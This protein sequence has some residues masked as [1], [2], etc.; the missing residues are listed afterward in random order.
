IEILSAENGKVVSKFVVE[1][2]HLNINK[3]LFGGYLACLVDIGGSF[4]IG[5]QSEKLG[6]ST[7][8]QLSFLRSAKEGDVVI[9]ESQLEKMGRNVA[10]TTVRLSVNGKPIAHG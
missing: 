5:T 3:H 9:M 7:D 6:V 10:F 4:A 8:L 2:E 1:K